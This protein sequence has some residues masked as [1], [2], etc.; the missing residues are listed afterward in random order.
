[1][2]ISA[3]SVNVAVLLF[4]LSDASDVSQPHLS[5]HLTEKNPKCVILMAH[6]TLVNSGATVL[7]LN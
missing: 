5:A 7:N 2:L 6:V 1:M 3:H 4:S